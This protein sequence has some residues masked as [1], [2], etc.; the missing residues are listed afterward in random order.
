V[1]TP[2]P[3]PLPLPPPCRLYSL[4]Q[5]SRYPILRE[6]SRW[7]DS[8]PE[9][10]IAAGLPYYV[11]DHV[12]ARLRTDQAL[13]WTVER[14]VQADLRRYWTVSC[15]EEEAER[16]ELERRSGPAGGMQR[17][18]YQRKL[19]AHSSPGCA[20]MKKFFGAGGGGRAEAAGEFA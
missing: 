10:G 15:G 4:R 16:R 8:P 13:L 14:G 6:T 12:N 5:T 19:Q 7:H 2:T 11:R 18:F 3:Y 17:A 20:N 9:P 1:L